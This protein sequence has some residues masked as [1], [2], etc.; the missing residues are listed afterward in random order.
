MRNFFLYLYTFRRIYIFSFV[1][2]LLLS[3]CK[4][5]DNWLDIKRDKADVIPKSLEQ[6]QAL[7][8]NTNYM[9]S[10]SNVGLAGADN[11]YIEFDNWQSLYAAEKNTYIWAK[12]MYQGDPSLFWNEQYVIIGY[13]NVV[14]EALEKLERNT[15]NEA[16]FRRIK[17]AALF[18]RGKAFY[19]LVTIFAKQYV[20]STAIDDPGILLRLSADV[21]LKYPRASLGESFAQIIKDLKEAESLLPLTNTYQTRPTKTAVQAMLGRVFLNMGNYTDALNYASQALS[22]SDYLIDFNTLN[23]A[24]GS[25][26][27]PPLPNNKEI[28]YW[29]GAISVY[30]SMAADY[31][32]IVD[33][34]L[35]DS[36]ETN[37]LRK[38]VF[39]ND[40][41]NKRRTFKGMY[42]TQSSCFSGVGV[43]E[44]YLIKAESEARLGQVELAMGTLN[45]LLK[46][47]WKTGTFVP[48][49][50]N[51]PL[52][53][54]QIILRE[55]RK[56]LPF[57]GNLRWED[58]KRLNLD[59]RFAKTLTR[60][61]N[62]TIYTLLPNDNRYV[63]PI[64]DNEI[65]L[66]NIKQNPR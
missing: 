13:A 30:A 38:T 2:G 50:A 45:T 49:V 8:D 44:V 63:H 4:K 47:R 58:L 21:A 11:H 29:S 18:Y 10:V 3:S 20:A 33:S 53:S 56:E 36:Y 59:T 17:G 39:Y 62:G 6:L 41:G 65:A 42:T 46:K 22:S 7:L 5:Q 28:I 16:D 54:L 19:D 24:F 43:N 66:S 40:Y 35:F 32:G 34:T 61:L 23:N 31:I 51:N 52:E 64:P 48:L 12:D 25:Y 60:N 15:S 55:R 57:T 1:V 37:D 27:F 14:L 26:P 9:N